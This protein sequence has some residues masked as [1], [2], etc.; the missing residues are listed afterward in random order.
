MV[1]GNAKRETNVNP[2]V[3]LDQQGTC[4]RTSAPQEPRFPVHAAVEMLATNQVTG[5]T[6]M[7]RNEV[8]TVEA[9]M[10]A[11]TEQS[12]EACESK[13]VSFVLL[14]KRGACVNDC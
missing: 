2:D 5:F 7:E 10:N 1:H 13:N 11:N 3:S 12:Q 8:A 4:S 14:H 6:L 9:T